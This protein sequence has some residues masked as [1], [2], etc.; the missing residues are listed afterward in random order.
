MDILL[1]FLEETTDKIFTGWS[2]FACQHTHSIFQHAHKQ[3]PH[4]FYE[5]HSLMCY[6]LRS[7]TAAVLE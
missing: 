5:G 3:E 6:V 4:F 1:K 7:L 2:C